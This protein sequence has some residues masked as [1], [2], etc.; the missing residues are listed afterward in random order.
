MERK[1]YIYHLPWYQCSHTLLFHHEWKQLN[2]RGTKTILFISLVPQLNSTSVMKPEKLIQKS[3]FVWYGIKH[4]STLSKYYVF[5]EMSGIYEL[6]V[7]F[8]SHKK[9]QIW[10]ESRSNQYFEWSKYTVGYHR[11]HNFKMIISSV[12][13]LNHTKLCVCRPLIKTRRCHRL[14]N[15]YF[16]WIIYLYL[17]ICFWKFPT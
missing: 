17:D 16:A 2:L 10:K 1:S 14:D 11:K 15:H 3:H 13:I 4:L 5:L 8:T 6:Y 12:H 9:F 7:N